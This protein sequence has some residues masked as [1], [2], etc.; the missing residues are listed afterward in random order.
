M[1]PTVGRAVHYNGRGRAFAA[2]INTVIDPETVH[3]TVFE[4]ERVKHKQFVKRG[5][6]PGEWDWTP[7]QKKINEYNKAQRGDK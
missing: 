2:T 4:P 3:L 5:P 7:Y 6:K 1:K